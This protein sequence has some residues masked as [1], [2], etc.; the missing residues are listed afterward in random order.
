MTLRIA[1]PHAA[2]AA[3]GAAGGLPEGVEAAWYEE[4]EDGALAGAEVLWLERLRTAD[5]ETAVR[6]GDRL[7]WIFYLGAGVDRMPFGLLRE[8]GLV[9]TNGSGLGANTVADHA[10]AMLLAAARGLPARV[11]A[12]ARREWRAPQPPPVELA[13]TRALVHGYGQIGRAIGRRLRGFD[14]E[15]TGVRR[16]PEPGEAEVVGPDAW[17]PLLGDT[18][19]VVLATPLTEGTR[20]VVGTPELAAMK[21]GAWLVNIARGGLV[22]QPALEAALAEGHIGGACLDTT[23]PEPLPADSPLWHLPNV[24]LTPHVAGHVRGARERAARLLLDNLA[25]HLSDRPL[26]N[27]VDLNAGY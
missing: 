16:T 11:Q 15:V 18:D 23:D 4:L 5:I 13:G 17:R 10:V 12:Q 22:D 21:P 3:I 19:W 20:H 14:V 2:E 27:V 7:R 26:R 24:L 1:L 6:A 9:L 25:R 8:R